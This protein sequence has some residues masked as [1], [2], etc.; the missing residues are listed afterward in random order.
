MKYFVYLRVEVLSTLFCIP[1]HGEKARGHSVTL[2]VSF[3]KP[4]LGTVH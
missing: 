4:D 1:G 3:P 2:T